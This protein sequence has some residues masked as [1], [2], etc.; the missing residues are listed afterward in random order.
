MYF[1]ERIAEKNRYASID[2][3]TSYPKNSTVSDC[4]YFSEHTGI[5]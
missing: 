2:N 3:F 5:G 1:S 4:T